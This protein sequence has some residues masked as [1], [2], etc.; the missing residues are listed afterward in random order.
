MAEMFMNC[1][2]KMVRIM[3]VVI[4]EA[5]KVGNALTFLGKESGIAWNMIGFGIAVPNQ[6]WESFVL[7]AEEAKA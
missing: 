2:E 1:S 4:E 3:F 6:R 7:I 5:L